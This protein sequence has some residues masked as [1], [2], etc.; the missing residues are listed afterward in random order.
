MHILITGGTG[1]IGRALC[2]ELLAQGHRVTVLSRSKARADS[3]CDNR[4]VTSTRAARMRRS[5]S[6]VVPPSRIARRTTDV[7]R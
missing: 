1:F 3:T 5:T 7:S 2:R 6:G 4:D